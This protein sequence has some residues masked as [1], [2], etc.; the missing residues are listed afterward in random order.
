MRTLRRLAALAAA[1]ALFTATPLSPAA[2]QDDLPR[3][4]V[5]VLPFTGL[6]WPHQQLSEY[7]PS[8]PLGVGL[9][10]YY[11]PRFSLAL[12]LSTSWH[13]GGP[14]GSS[15]TQ[16]SSL[17]LLGRWWFPRETWSP[18]LQAGA[19]GYQAEVDERGSETQ[20]GGPGVS[21]GGGA[22]V[23]LP[24]RFFL[25]GELRSNWV[26]GKARSGGDT[27]WIGHTQALAWVGYKLP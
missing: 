1:A 6:T 11:T 25:Q 13:R 14:G 4:G 3:L 21:A 26:R 17:Q 23:P 2:A 20:F 15:D 10:V 27:R 19:G 9:E 12:D 18:F 5:R 7:R 24:H 22:E 8:A 16:V